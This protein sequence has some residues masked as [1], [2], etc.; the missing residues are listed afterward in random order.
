MEM[1]LRHFPVTVIPSEHLTSFSVF[2]EGS[3][4]IRFTLPTNTTL[5]VEQGDMV[6]KGQ[7]LSEGS[8]DLQELFKVAGRTAVQEYILKEEDLLSKSKNSPF[9]G[10]ALK[11][12][13]ELTMIAGKIVWER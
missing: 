2:K 11:G 7:Q 3:Y 6:V 10:K 8:I 13:N 4:E 5:M 9:L 12:R 1:L